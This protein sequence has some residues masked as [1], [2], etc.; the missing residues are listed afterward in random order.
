MISF[1]LQNQNIIDP[2]AIIFILFL[3]LKWIRIRRS[4]QTQSIQTPDVA[5]NTGYSISSKDIQMVAGDDVI[6]TQL[7][8]ACAYIQLGKNQ[9]AKSILQ[10]VIKEGSSTQQEEAKK[11]METI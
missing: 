4:Y 11:L 8:L 1:L 9:L 2:I 3:L 10:H 5:T 6:T 7:D